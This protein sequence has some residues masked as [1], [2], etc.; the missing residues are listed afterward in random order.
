[1]NKNLRINKQNNSATKSH[2]KLF[3]QWLSWM[4]AHPAWAKELLAESTDRE[5]VNDDGT[6]TRYEPCVNFHIN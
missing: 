3:T 1:M 6:E 2:E 4:E 5:K